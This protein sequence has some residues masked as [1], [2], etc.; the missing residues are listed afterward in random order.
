MCGVGAYVEYKQLYLKAR[1]MVSY[2]NDW[3][4]RPVCYFT[5]V[6]IF[7]WALLQYCP[8]KILHRCAQ[9]SFYF[10]TENIFIPF[11]WRSVVVLSFSV[12]PLIKCLSCSKCKWQFISWGFLVLWCKESVRQIQSSCFQHCLFYLVQ[13]L[14]FVLCC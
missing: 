14:N 4:V 1:F 2:A 7:K 11:Y 5:I 6:L 10:N 8:G 13:R 3:K 9:L 12:M